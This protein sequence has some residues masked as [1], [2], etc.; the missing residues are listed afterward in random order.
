MVDLKKGDTVRLK[1]G[2]PLMTITDFGNYGPAG[3]EDGV[4]CV[5]FEKNK[6]EEAEFDRAVLEVG[7]NKMRT[8]QLL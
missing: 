2:G 3:P 6:R 4:K 8:G 5:W 7:S 1:S